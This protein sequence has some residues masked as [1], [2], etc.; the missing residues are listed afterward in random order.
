MFSKAH[1]LKARF[2][3]VVLLEGA[4]NLEECNLD[5]AVTGHV[6]LK[7]IRGSQ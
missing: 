5:L 7:K 6:T 3:A 1:L 4:E 2:Q